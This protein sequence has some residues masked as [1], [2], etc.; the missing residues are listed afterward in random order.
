MTFTS[1]AA[2]LDAVVLAVVSREEQ[3]TYGYRITQQIKEVL[4]LS[5]SALYPVLR[6]L[7]KDQ[8]LTVYDETINGRNR[9]YYQTTSKGLEQLDR[10]RADWKE[11]S[12]KIDHLFWGEPS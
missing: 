6:G 8:C 5:E 12:Q 2:L 11:Y 9:R 10:Y 1:S 3:G 7:Q 4:D